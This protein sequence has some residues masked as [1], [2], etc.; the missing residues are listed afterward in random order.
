MLF[1]HSLGGSFC[2]L[3]DVNKFA[4]GD[5]A[6]YRKIAEYLS[7]QGL[8]P[9]SLSNCKC[10]D[11][12]LTEFHGWYGT[13]GLKSLQTI[14]SASVDFIFSNAVFEH[15]NKREVYST[16]KELHR[17]CKK[18]GVCSHTIDLRD[19]FKDSL[20]HL[21]IPECLW[22][23]T[24]MNRSFTNRL[25]YPDYLNLFEMAGFR[26]VKL[27]K[28]RWKRLPVSKEKLATPY[29]N[30]SLDDLLIESFIIVLKKI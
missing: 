30:Y 8:S 19:H 13:S 2:Y 10:L 20:N 1:T 29:R 28:R 27:F 11:D 14:P 24:G 18:D 15:V 7:K 21:I 5:I 22:E 26:I 17:I 23:A 3:N 12:L 4:I 6:E 9:A 25:L 16:I